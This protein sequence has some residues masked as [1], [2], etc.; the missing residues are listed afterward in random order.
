M[1][2]IPEKLN[3][4]IEPMGELAFTKKLYHHVAKHCF[5]S[6]GERWQQDF[7]NAVFIPALNA[8]RMG[9]PQAPELREFMDKYR[10]LLSEITNQRCR[11]GTRHLHYTEQRGRIPPAQVIEVWEYGRRIKIVAKAFV[12]NGE[13]HPY[14]LCTGFRDYHSFTETNFRTEVQKRQNE[15][16]FIKN[17]PGNDCDS[18]MTLIADHSGFDEQAE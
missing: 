13:I 14:I 5:D 17:R 18:K 2:R 11:E 1:S 4:P 16:S 8:Y 6:P 3:I 15:S 9:Y 7:G 12:R 10:K